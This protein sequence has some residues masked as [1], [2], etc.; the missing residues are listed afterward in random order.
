MTDDSRAKVVPLEPKTS[1]K[2]A[3]AA[4]SQQGAD[5][6]Y[7]GVVA[8]FPDKPKGLKKKESELWDT[9]AQ[10]LVDLGVLS[11]I[12]VAVF[13]RYVVL[14]VEWQ[15]WNTECQKERGMKSIQVFAT[16]ARQMSVEAVLRKQAAEQLAKVEQQLGMTP[17]ARQAIKLENPNQ[18]SLDL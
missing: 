4:G 5:D 15:H 8:G 10:K 11:E 12:D 18:G 1:A 14:Y 3:T 13:H 6:L 16:G 17:R 9:M 7:Q 2:S